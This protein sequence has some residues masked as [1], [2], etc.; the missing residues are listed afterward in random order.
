MQKY[1]FSFKAYIKELITLQ[2]PNPNY[3]SLRDDKV[4]L[5]THTIPLKPL[6]KIKVTLCNHQADGQ[7]YMWP[8]VWCGDLQV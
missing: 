6:R 2:F 5:L 7:L 4:S 1:T 3:I 8:D